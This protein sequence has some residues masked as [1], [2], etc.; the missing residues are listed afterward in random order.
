MALTQEQRE[1][2]R[3]GIGGSDCAAIL[4][5]SKWKTPLDVYLDKIFGPKEETENQFTE[6][7]NRLE[8][9]IIQAFEDKTGLKCEIEPNTLYHPEHSFMFANIDARIVGQNAILECKTAS[10]YNAKRWSEEGGETLPEEYMLQCAHYAEVCNIDTVYVAV[11]IGGND[12]RVYHYTRNKELGA[13][14]IKA[15]HNFWHNHVLKE[16]APDPINMDDAINL[17]QHANNDKAITAEGNIKHAF[18]KV[19]DIKTQIKKLELELKNQLLPIYEAMKDAAILN[20]EYGNTL[21]TWKTQTSNRFNTT[22]FKKE[23]QDIYNQYLTTTETRVFKIKG[24]L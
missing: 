15:E 10:Q 23:R 19:R 2:R 20:D 5:L 6:W 21:A 1:L 22:T 7:G 9:L 16:V 18:D 4:G 11:L 12:F 17:W 3:N 14:I 13:A 8:P 24:E